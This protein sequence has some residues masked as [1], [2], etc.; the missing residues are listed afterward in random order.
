MSVQEYIMREN[1]PEEFYSEMESIDEMAAFD[2]FMDTFQ[3]PPTKEEVEAWQIADLYD[4]DQ[5]MLANA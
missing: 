1:D 5:R 3:G 2:H 4:I